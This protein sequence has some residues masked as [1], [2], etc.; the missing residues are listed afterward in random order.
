MRHS[1]LWVTCI[2]L[3][4]CAAFVTAQPVLANPIVAFTLAF[5][6]EGFLVATNVLA[7]DWDDYSG[8]LK[9]SDAES[10]P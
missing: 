2:L 10:D 3:A 8:H 5:E 1:I 4:A 6:R 7:S 9:F